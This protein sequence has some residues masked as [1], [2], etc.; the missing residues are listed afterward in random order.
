LP[1]FIN[2]EKENLFFYIINDTSIPFIIDQ[3]ERAIK[4]VDILDRE[5]QDKY[6]F[7]IELKLKSSY[8]IKFQEIYHSHQKNSS[9]YFQ[10]SNKYYRKIL[11][12]IYI[13]DINDN[14][15]QCDYFHQHTFLNENQIQTNIF[16]V[17]AFDPDR[18]K[19][20]FEFLS[21]N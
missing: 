14:I 13:N 21:D 20:L 17:H 7:E 10:Y 18:G 6:T 16:Q 12:T 3:N 5:K 9:S 4:L 2:H 8:E 15:P 11:I 19:Y 1:L